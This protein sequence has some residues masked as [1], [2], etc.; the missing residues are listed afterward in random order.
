MKQF[1]LSDEKTAEFK[2]VAATAYTKPNISP[3][4]D[5]VQIQVGGRTIATVTNSGFVGSKNA[6]GAKIHSIIEGISGQRPQL[7]QR[8]AET[9]AEA[10]DGEVSKLSTAQTQIEMVSKVRPHMER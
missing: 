8:R 7:A 1:K 5:Y 3:E 6:W 2:E 9:I 10:F 4:T